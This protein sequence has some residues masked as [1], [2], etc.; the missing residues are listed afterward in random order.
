MSRYEGKFQGEAAVSLDV[1]L[2]LAELA[3]QQAQLSDR[4]RQAAIAC[5]LSASE[6]WRNASQ[7]LGGA[8]A[9]RAFARREDGSGLSSG[10]K[11]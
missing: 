9:G 2:L 6:G 4:D 5:Y 10:E 11:E 3:G 8:F 7:R 1:S